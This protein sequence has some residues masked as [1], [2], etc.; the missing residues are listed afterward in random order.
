MGVD[1]HTKVALKLEDRG[2][3]R[4]ALAEWRRLAARADLPRTERANILYRIGKLRQELGEHA[5]A[6]AAYYRA[7]ALGVP[8]KT[9][10]RINRRLQQCFEETGRE[11]GLQ[12]DLAT[13]V[14]LKPGDPKARVVAEI[15]DRKIT[16]ADLDRF[17]E[18]EIEAQLRPMA[19]FMSA[20]DLRARR[21]AMLDQFRSPR[22][23]LMMLQQMVQRDILLREARSRKMQDSEAYRRR[24]R[25]KAGDL[26]VERFTLE[27]LKDRV[28]VD[29]GDV[30]NHYEANKKRYVVPG[31]VRLRHIRVADKAGAEA[32]LTRVLKGEDFAKLASE[33]SEDAATKAKGGLIDADVRAD[34]MVP[35]VGRAPELV[36]DALPLKP[37]AVLPKVYKVGDGWEVAKVEAKTPERRIPFDQAREAVRNEV[38]GRKI[39]EAQRR[40]L[41]EL[42]R[43]YDVVVNAG[44]FQPAEGGGRTEAKPK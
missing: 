9:Q 32:L 22:A 37:G 13:R 16:D 19:S 31:S 8:N 29:P 28:R 44:L 4:A 6:V 15:G 17:I 14:A 20:D 18:D 7:E 5:A 23:R 12:R 30:R 34:G 24:L 3:R 35:G 2:F 40:M 33:H 10:G 38:Y 21:K 43:K 1:R 39:Q 25:R 41:D 42:K 36:R 27:N 11:S 26:L